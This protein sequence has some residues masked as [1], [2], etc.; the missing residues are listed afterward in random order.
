[1]IEPSF[2]EAFGH[3]I[4]CD[5]IRIEHGG[6]LTL[7][8][9]YPNVM[10]VHGNFPFTLPKFG[11]QVMYSERLD[12]LG[13]K[14]AVLRLFASWLPDDKPLIEH[15]L[16]TSLPE[17]EAPEAPGIPPADYGHLSLQ[18][19]FTPLVIERPGL[20]RARVIRDNQVIRL[21]A[22]RIG[23]ALPTSTQ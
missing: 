8:G 14:K 21:G 23:K 11:V 3:A 19:M 18:V 16:P 4:F 2:G 22:L 13:K 6:K 1:M 10:F 5:D 7:V 9:T 15:D 12:V 17:I 20:I